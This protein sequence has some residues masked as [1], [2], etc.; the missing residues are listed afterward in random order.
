MH[1]FVSLSCIYFSELFK[2]LEK[3]EINF[4]VWKDIP[5]EM[6]GS[7]LPEPIKS[8]KEMSFCEYCPLDSVLCRMEIWR[9]Y[10]RTENFSHP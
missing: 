3:N 5:V 6:S 1:F 4:D 10:S 8:F 9:F 7:N 2:N